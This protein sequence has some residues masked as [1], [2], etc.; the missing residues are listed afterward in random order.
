MLVTSCLI[1]LA[2]GSEVSLSLFSL[3]IDLIPFELGLA[4]G[5]VLTIA[6]TALSFGAVNVRQFWS[7]PFDS[8]HANKL[9]A[10]SCIFM[11]T[12]ILASMIVRWESGGRYGGMANGI[13]LARAIVLESG[14]CATMLITTILT[15]ENKLLMRVVYFPLI[16]MLVFCAC[17]IMVDR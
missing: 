4:I 11:T 17:L 5:A 1:A 10:Y 8:K 14:L 13:N 3:A 16:A 7:E 6:S 15:T 12:G 9:I 2:V